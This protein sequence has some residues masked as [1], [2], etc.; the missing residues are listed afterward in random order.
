MR[1]R[2]FLAEQEGVVD[3]HDLHVWAL[4]T[5]GCALTAHLVMPAGHPGDAALDRVVE[6]LSAR[7]GMRHVTL[8]VD[9]GTSEHRCA[10]DVPGGEHRQAPA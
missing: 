4:S 6:S 5:T 1:V 2:G 10:L 7:F 8:Q 3:V 9:L